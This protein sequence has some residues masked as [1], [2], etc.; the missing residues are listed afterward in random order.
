MSD[1]SSKE[2]PSSTEFE[3][4]IKPSKFTPPKDSIKQQPKP[5]SKKRKLSKTYLKWK[6]RQIDPNTFLHDDDMTRLNIPP[7]LQHS[8]L[9]GIPNSPIKKLRPWQQ[10]LFEKP[11]WKERQNSIILVPTSGGKTVAADVAIAQL[12]TSDKKAKA[13]FALPF[14]ALANEKYNEYQK[15]FFPYSVR[16]YYMNIGGNEF[17]RGHIAICTYE[18]AHTILNSALIS[19][20]IDKIKLV[21][22]DE[23]HMIGDESRGPVVESLITKILLMNTQ[24]LRIIGL[25]ATI[26][27]QDAVRLSQWIGGFHFISDSRPSQ[28]IHYIKNHKGELYKIQKNNTITR[29]H[30]LKQNP[31]DPKHLIEPIRTILSRQSLSS[32]IIFVNTRNETHKT[33]IFIAKNLPMN[34][35][36]EILEARKKLLQELTRVTNY[37]D[38]DITMC[39]LKGIGIHHAGLMLEER[40]LY[41][42]AAR[43]KT[44]SVLVATTTL[45]AG[46]NIH[47]VSSVFILDIYRIG[48]NKRKIL[49]PPAQ[50]TQMVG[51]AGRTEKRPGEAFIFANTGNESEISDILKLSRHEI[52]DIVPH[53]LDE[54][55]VDRFFLQC[56]STKLVPAKDGLIMFISK[57]LLGLTEETL[58]DASKRLIENQLVDPATFEATALGKA[59]AISNLTIEEGIFMSHV[60]KN[61]QR[62]LCLDDEVHLLSLCV[63]PSIA[64]SIRIKKSYDSDIWN[65]IFTNHL[66][67]IKLITGIQND[68]EIEKMKYLPGIFGGDGRVNPPLDSIL[69]RVYIAVL[70]LDLINE[71]PLN[72][73]KEDFGVERG[74]I[75]SLQMQCSSF[76]SQTAKFCEVYGSVLLAST[77]NRFRTRLNFAARSE[78]LSLMVLPSISKQSARALFDCG[79]LSPNEILTLKHEQLAA[80]ISPVGEDGLKLAPTTVEYDFARQIL[81]EAKE[82]AKGLEKIEQLEEMALKNSTEL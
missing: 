37:I 31:N 11:E 28:V 32:I 61:I 5:K 82:Y 8:Y 16:P 69:D 41:E 18:K 2:Y 29:F 21:I 33:A 66:H 70:L 63:S 25:T 10:S 42:E 55:Q 54:G 4:D 60:I 6:E 77:L 80:I 14:V 34:S 62:N 44:L 22:I 48:H 45:S 13:I 46:I 38:S 1:P 78:L 57:T 68:A 52:A 74:F 73:I 59:I 53:L 79:L 51:R 64:A 56:L 35:S 58:Q 36:A 20:Y 7:F 24:Q 26:N 72:T 17:H 49:M 23:I 39:I 9:S 76:A 27:S 30:N 19:N 81:K 50:F 67:V 40:K 65:R 3:I 12:L 15:R 47:S 71:V 43:N 75:Q